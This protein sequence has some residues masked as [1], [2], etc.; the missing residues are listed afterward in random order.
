MGEGHAGVVRRE[1]RDLLPPAHLIAAQPVGEDQRRPAAGD[2][3]VEI[4]ERSLQ[5]ADG[6]LHWVS[7]QKNPVI[8]TGA[9]RSGGT[10]SCAS[11]DMNRSLDYARDDGRPLSL[12]SAC[13]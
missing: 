6:A 11:A 3:V 10:C 8:P 5:L 13:I 2:L 7:P 4:A 1:V 12:I 9:K